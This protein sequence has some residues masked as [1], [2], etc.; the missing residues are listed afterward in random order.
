MFS[1][2]VGG[3]GLVNLVRFL[4]FVRKCGIFLRVGEKFKF[5]YFFI[6]RWDGF[7]FIVMVFSLGVFLGLGG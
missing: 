7:D 3:G 1:W 6:V 2:E 4:E 5:F